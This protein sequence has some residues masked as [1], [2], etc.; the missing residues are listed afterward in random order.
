[1]RQGSLSLES[2]AMKTQAERVEWAMNERGLNKNQLETAAKM[3]PG[4]LSNAFKRK[5]DS[6]KG[7]TLDKLAFALGVD[8][9]WLTNGKG[10]MPSLRRYEPAE[11][12]ALVNGQAPSS[13]T[14]PKPISTVVERDPVDSGQWRRWGDLPGW[15]E[16]TELAIKLFGDLLPEVAFWMPANIRGKDWPQKVDA[17]TVLEWAKVCWWQKERDERER[18]EYEQAKAELD[19]YRARMAKGQK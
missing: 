3:N 11:I 6:M 17:L 14:T 5:S 1:M 8:V 13:E 12:E 15:K 19:A 7:E 16:A 10:P 18:L 4:Y 2:V 9:R